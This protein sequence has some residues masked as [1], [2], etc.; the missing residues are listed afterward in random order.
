MEKPKYSRK[1]EIQTGSIYQPS[2]TEDPG[3]KTPSQGRY[4][5]KIKD[6]ILSISKQSKK[7]RATSTYSHLQ[8]QIYQESTVISL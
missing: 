2:P 7:Q 1:K 8:K 5:Q 3:R 4:Q 6:K